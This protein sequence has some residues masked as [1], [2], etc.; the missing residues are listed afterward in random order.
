MIPLEWGGDTRPGVRAT[1]MPAT[2]GRDHAEQPWPVRLLT[3]KLTEYIAKAPAVWVEGQ[4]VQLT[5]RP[6]QTHLL[7][8]PARHRRRPVLLGDR[9]RP[10][11]RRAGRPARGRCPRRR[12]R[13]PAAVPAPRVA[14][15]G[16]RRPAPG[17]ASASCSPGWSTCAGCSP[18]RGCSTPTASARCRSCRASSGWS[19][20]GPAPPSGTS[21]RTP[22]G[23]G[24]RSGSTSAR[25]P[26]RGPTAVP[27]VVAAIAR[28]T[29]SPRS[30]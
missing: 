13:P 5:R 14:Q 17:R 8:H 10:G 3:A 19:A 25:S 24:P 16:G 21:S 22:A 26:C 1:A 11:A 27:D 20:A 9:A 15:P 4:V 7:P 2:A 28:W 18:P 12:P 23:A 29:P 30:T 6:G